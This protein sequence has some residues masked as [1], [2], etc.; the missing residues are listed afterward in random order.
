MSADMKVKPQGSTASEITLLNV[1]I[2][3]YSCDA[4]LANDQQTP[5]GPRYQISGTALISTEDWTDMEDKIAR[6]SS[7]MEYIRLQQGGASSA[8]LVEL[9]KADSDIGGPFLKITG[10]QILGTGLVMVRWEATDQQ[11]LCNDSPLVSH[12]WTTNT[13]VD[14]VG[15]LTVTYNG[16]VRVN[17]SRAGGATT[18]AS[19]N[20]T[21][22]NTKAA[23]A[24]LFR[25]AALRA[26]PAYGW[27]RDTQTYAYDVTS[28]ELNYQV[29]DKQYLHDLP[30]G[31]RVGDMD[32]SYERT[33]SDAGV[34]MCSVTV[35]LEGD[36]GLSAATPTAGNRR[37]VEAAV[38]LSKA[39]I[40]ASYSS[41]LI[42]RMRITERS[43]LSGYSVRFELDAQVFS[44]SQAGSGA[45]M[46]PL[47][48]MIGQKFGV[49]R[50][51][52]RTMSGYGSP[53]PVTVGDQTTNNAYYWL[54]HWLNNNL[55]GMNCDGKDAVL[56]SPNWTV[57]QPDENLGT[58][59]VVVYADTAG[60]LEMNGSFD[61]KFSTSSTQVANDSD[62]YVEVVAHTTSTT[63]VT[64]SANITRFSTMYLDQADFLVQVRKPVVRVRE[65]LEVSK[66][67]RAPARVMR[68]MPSGSILVYENWDVTFGKFDGQ[69]QRVFVGIY[70]REVEM[71]DSGA[72]GGAAGFGTV[73]ASGGLGQVRRWSAPNGKV[74]AALSPLGTDA[75]QSVATGVFTPLAS[76][77]DSANYDVP[78]QAY[79]G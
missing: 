8:K 12:T 17:R 77:M 28:N 5:I 18:P 27:R 72:G 1:Q 65:R 73:S 42:T 74:V 37:L 33:A 59:S 45:V 35:E 68:P 67:N 57:F 63:H 2:E 51:S 78:A 53:V 44:S 55:N 50:T 25:N 61:G 38:A 62:G 56:P 15:R 64:N 70:E 34:G 22:W 52:P 29:I 71:Y 60:V 48:Y 49:A 66:A 24:D 79:T 41:V 30:D 47:A 54:P 6:N 58:V 10:T 46:V 43:I 21:D 9:E 7:R 36:M 31:C 23:Y 4:S 69:G 75:S 39:R 26:L 32:F 14:A 19:R 3:S 20:S 16:T 40:N 11:S 76:P 13:Q